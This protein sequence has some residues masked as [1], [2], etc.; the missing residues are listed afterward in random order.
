MNIY[1][2]ILIL[3]AVFLVGANALAWAEDYSYLESP[4]DREFVEIKQQITGLLS[5]NNKLSVEYNRVKRE[6]EELKAKAGALTKE[7]D[8]MEEYA[9]STEGKKGE[10]L[11]HLADMRKDLE[12][13]KSDALVKESRVAY[14][15]GE[16]LDLTETMKLKELTFKNL[17]YQRRE[18]EMENKLKTSM[19]ETSQEKEKSEL[20]LLQRK[21]QD[22]ERK[23]ELLSKQVG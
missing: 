17:D 21:L 10:R 14:L 18:L 12:E 22:L 20:V 15:K 23:K 7:I 6:F 5:A 13:M 4:D 1:L 2:R 9:Q 16:I 3:L 11:K 8:Q 19:A